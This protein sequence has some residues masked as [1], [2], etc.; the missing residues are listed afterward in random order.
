MTTEHL[1][2][3]LTKAELTKADAK[4]DTSGANSLPMW[5]RAVTPSWATA[6]CC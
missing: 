1:S 4:A 6:P 2:V 3:E 5:R